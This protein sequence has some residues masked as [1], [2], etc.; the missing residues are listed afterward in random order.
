M[1]ANLKPLPPDAAHGGTTA[2]TLATRLARE[3]RER[4]H[5]G[6]PAGGGTP[7]ELKMSQIV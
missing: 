6:R 7:S 2:R 4:H 3:T 5:R 1:Q